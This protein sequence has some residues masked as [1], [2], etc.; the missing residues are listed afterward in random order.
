MNDLDKTKLKLASIGYESTDTVQATLYKLAKRL[1]SLP[2]HILVVVYEAGM[3]S[4]DAYREL[5]S[6]AASRKYMQLHII[7]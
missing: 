6:V 7:W 1:F 3:I 5:L 4:N 2:K